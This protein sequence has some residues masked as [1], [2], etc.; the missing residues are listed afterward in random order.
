MIDEKEDKAATHEDDN[1]DNEGAT[2]DKDKEEEE[3][4]SS[5]ESSEEEDEEQEGQEKEKEPEPEQEKEEQMTGSQKDDPDY[6]EKVIETSETC[7]DLDE[8]ARHFINAFV[9][10]TC[11][12]F[13]AL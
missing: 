8:Q 1:T 11:S 3:E 4:E 6:V 9:W 12:L 10:D 2:G 7:G 5:E 13:L